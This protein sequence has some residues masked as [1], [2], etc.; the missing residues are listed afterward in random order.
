ML[1]GKIILG[2]TNEPISKNI[3]WSVSI[4]TKNLHIHQVRVRVIFDYL[5]WRMRMS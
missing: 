2:M 5:N 4:L 1:Y 3:V